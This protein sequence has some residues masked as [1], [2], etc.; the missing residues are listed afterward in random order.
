M[1]VCIRKWARQVGKNEEMYVCIGKPGMG[2]VYRRRR[3]RKTR[4][5]RQ[6]I[7]GLKQQQ[8]SRLQNSKLPLVINGKQEE[9]VCQ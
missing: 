1:Y 4:L 5:N 7:R 2:L 3:R 6:T 9:K 8:K